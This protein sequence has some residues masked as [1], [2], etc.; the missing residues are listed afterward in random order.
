M[1][2]PKTAEKLAASEEITDT[3]YTF[4]ISP[5]GYHCVYTHLY[6]TLQRHAGEMN[7]AT[8]EEEFLYVTSASTAEFCRA[9]SVAELFL[10]NERHQAMQRIYGCGRCC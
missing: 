1:C 9:L 8:G 3:L 7:A 2:N 10:E 6:Q 4:D 5:T